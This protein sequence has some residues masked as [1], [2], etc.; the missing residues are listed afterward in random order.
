[1]LFSKEEEGQAFHAHRLNDC[2]KLLQMLCSLQG[3]LTLVFECKTSL[4]LGSYT[5]NLQLWAVLSL[6]PPQNSIM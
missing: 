4:P 1:M 3:R 6:F 5:Q 2:N